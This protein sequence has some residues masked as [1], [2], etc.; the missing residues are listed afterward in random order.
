MPSYNAIQSQWVNPPVSNDARA[1]DILDGMALM[2]QRV[3]AFLDPEHDF[4]NNFGSSP[5]E[6]LPDV[7]PMALHWI[8]GPV[9]LG[10]IMSGVGFPGG[11]REW[12]IPMTVFLALGNNG[13]PSA[14]LL[15]DSVDWLHAYDLAYCANTQLGGLVRYAK[16]TSGQLGPIE[17][18]KRAY[19]GWLIQI[20]VLTQYLSGVGAG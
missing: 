3:L 11:K 19:F 7:Y 16:V 12:K 18:A 13:E 10:T 2:E 9:T 5:P 4:I 14:Q 1:R 6:K 20:E 8:G 15:R 17:Y